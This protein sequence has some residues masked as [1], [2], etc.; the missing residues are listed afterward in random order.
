MDSENQQLE[1]FDLLNINLPVFEGPLDLLLDLI[2]KKK[3]GH[4][5]ELTLSNDFYDYFNINSDTGLQESLKE[6]ST[7]E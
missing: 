1:I 3:M 6:K 7:E 2:R 5:N 4:T